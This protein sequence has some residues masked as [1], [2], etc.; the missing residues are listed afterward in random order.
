MNKLILSLTAAVFAISVP[1]AAIA[2]HHEGGHDGHKC[3][4]MKDGKM[5]C[6][7]KGEDG[8]MACHIMDKKK[9]D[10]SNMDHSKMDHGNM[11]HPETS[12]DKP[13]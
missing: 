4:K 13:N 10:H 12:T 5:K 7:K 1:S 9:L 3:E 2:K 8:K 6:C 11:K